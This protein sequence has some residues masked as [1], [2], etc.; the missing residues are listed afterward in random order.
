[1]PFK[2]PFVGGGGNQQFDF[3]IN[4]EENSM[5]G[6]VSKAGGGSYKTVTM[7]VDIIGNTASF[8]TGLLKHISYTMTLIGDGSAATVV[9]HD[10]IWGT[11]SGTVKR[12]K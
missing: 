9:V 1:M 11:T 4:R 10:T 5:S 8:K 7:G 12:I 3:I 2:D 6:R